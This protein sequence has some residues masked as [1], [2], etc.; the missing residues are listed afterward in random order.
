MSNSKHYR[1]ETT[2]PPNTSGF[3]RKPKNRKRI[4]GRKPYSR[5]SG[6]NPLAGMPDEAKAWVLGSM[7]LIAAA[8][9]LGPA[10]GFEVP[11]KRN[12]AAE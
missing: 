5:K 4:N 3:N 1:M 12:T 7:F 6:L 8:K 10:I 11:A 2:N 9:L